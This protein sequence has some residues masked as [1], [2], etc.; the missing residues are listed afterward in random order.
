[1]PN[2]SNAVANVKSPNV[3]ILLVAIL[4]VVDL[5]RRVRVVP[6]LLLSKAAA[7]VSDLTASLKAARHSVL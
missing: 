4:F 6:F 7:T 5:F 2:S 1:M 3:I